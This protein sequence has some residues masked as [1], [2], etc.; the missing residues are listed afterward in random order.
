MTIALTMDPNT[1]VRVTQA[2]L[3][4]DVY[5]VLT[6]QFWSKFFSMTTPTWPESLE[7]VANPRGDLRANPPFVPLATGLDNKLIAACYARGLCP[8]DLNFINIADEYGLPVRALILILT[9]PVLTAAVESEVCHL[10]L[11][12]YSRREGCR[13]AHPHERPPLSYG[14]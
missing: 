9:C 5:N 12:P 10:R 6:T 4:L 14:L 3:P 8:D 11:R 13:S 7:R 2:L 1:T